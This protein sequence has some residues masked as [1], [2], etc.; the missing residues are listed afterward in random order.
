[1]T[2]PPQRSAHDDSAVKDCC[3]AGEGRAAG[4][5]RLYSIF[6]EVDGL[7]AEYGDYME[8]VKRRAAGVSAAVEDSGLFIE[9]HTSVVCPACLQ[10]CC[11]NRHSYHELADIVCILALGER[12]PVYT[13]VVADTKPCQFLGEKGCSV[14]RALRPHRCNWYFCAPLL[15]HIKA[16]PAMEY[17]W[18]IAGLRDINEKREALLNA[19]AGG[20]KCA[21]YD[22]GRLMRESDEFFFT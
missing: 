16:V 3:E 17:R 11:I 13:R 22:I 12:P 21:G 18:F 8:E 20:L 15:D 14:R 19:F 2:R 10:V 9:Q 1:M 4:I 5:D 7:F 6:K